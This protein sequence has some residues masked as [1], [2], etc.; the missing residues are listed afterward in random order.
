[1]HSGASNIGSLFQ[2]SISPSSM[3]SS[4]MQQ[5]NA[6][7]VDL[8]QVQSTARPLQ[9]ISSAGQL[10]CSSTVQNIKVQEFTTNKLHLCG[11]CSNKFSSR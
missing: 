1:M 7:H 10:V 6:V 5:S 4:S 8:T 11:Y 9:S 3:S 2:T